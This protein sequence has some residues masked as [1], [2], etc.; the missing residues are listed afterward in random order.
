MLGLLVFLVAGY[1]PGEGGLGSL[2]EVVDGVV[3]GQLESL[4]KYVDAS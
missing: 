1:S 2:V 4:A 3:R